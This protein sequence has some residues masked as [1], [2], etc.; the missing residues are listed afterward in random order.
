MSLENKEH[1][2]NLKLRENI[3]V[4]FLGY[5]SVVDVWNQ[6]FSKNLSGEQPGIQV[7]SK[8][9]NVLYNIAILL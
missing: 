2:K 7:Q 9:Y 6:G 3:N 5:I 8:L 1:L 4:S